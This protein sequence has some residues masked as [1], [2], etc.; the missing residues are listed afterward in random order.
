MLSAM[1]NQINKKGKG[2]V[3]HKEAIEP[4]DMNKLYSSFVFDINIPSGLLNKVWCELCMYFCRRGRE[5]Q[6]DLL[7][8][9]FELKR[10]DK[11]LQYICQIGF[12]VTKTIR[13]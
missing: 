1:C 3:E 9:M 4:E 13:V 12:E 2:G 11:G 10:D 7:P 5:N 8:S 6:R